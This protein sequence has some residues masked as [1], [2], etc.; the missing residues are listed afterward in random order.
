M[1]TISLDEIWKPIFGHVGYEVSNMGGV[2]QTI[3]SRVVNRKIW[4]HI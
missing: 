4:S 3:I 1:R 2:H